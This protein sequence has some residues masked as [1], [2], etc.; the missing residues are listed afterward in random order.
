MMEPGAAPAGGARN[1]AP[2]GLGQQSVPTMGD[3]LEWLDAAPTKTGE[4]LPDRGGR[5]PPV[6]P[7][8]RPRGQKSPQWSAE[9]RASVAME[10]TRLAKACRAASP[11]ARGV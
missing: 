4:S 9:R 5:G 7:E 2:G 8:A 10:A 11:A 1:P 3:C 6:G